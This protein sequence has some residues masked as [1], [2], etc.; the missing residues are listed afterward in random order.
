MILYNFK[1]SEFITEKKIDSQI[2]E[3]QNEIKY[4]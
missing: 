3:V 1:D 4:R 2:S